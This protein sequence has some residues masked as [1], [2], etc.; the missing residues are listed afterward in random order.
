[1]VTLKEKLEKLK[2]SLVKQI[3]KDA[4]AIM[5]HASEELASSGILDRI[6]KVGEKLSP[7]ELKDTEEQVVS[8]EM[9]LEKGPLVLTFYRGVW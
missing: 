8:A 4:L 7:F 9:L 1:M 5:H 3:P 2:E 6:P